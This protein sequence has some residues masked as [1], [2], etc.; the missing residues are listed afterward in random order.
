[1]KLDDFKAKAHEIR[2]LQKARRKDMD[3]KLVE[4]LLSDKEFT[5]A[6]LK[7]IDEEGFCTI[8]INLRPSFMSVNDDLYPMV[9]NILRD[10]GK[11]SYPLTDQYGFDKKLSSI[12]T[13]WGLEKELRS[14]SIELV[15][16]CFNCGFRVYSDDNQAKICF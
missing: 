10:Y 9:R 3:I 16:A 2:E 12:E 11:G 13:Q 8:R 4:L 7:S 1:M 6:L 15:T 14:M 5:A